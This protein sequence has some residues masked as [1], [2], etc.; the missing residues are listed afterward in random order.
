MLNL[1]PQYR[2]PMHIQGL[3]G[4]IVYGLSTIPQHQSGSSVPLQVSLNK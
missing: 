1:L 4:F 3:Q 2:E